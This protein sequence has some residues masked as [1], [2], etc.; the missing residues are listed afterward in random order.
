MQK[1]G[2]MRKIKL[3]SKFFGVTTW[4]NS[5][6]KIGQL[7]EYNIKSI[8]LEESYKKCGGE[9]IPTPFSKK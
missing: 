7:R 3:I 5:T 6:M 2:L 9:T 4:D 8:F 1:N